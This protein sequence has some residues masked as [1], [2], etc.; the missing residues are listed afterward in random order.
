MDARQVSTKAVA[1]MAVSVGVVVGLVASSA[2]TN[3]YANT[4]S[5]VRPV[6]TATLATVPVAAVRSTSYDIDSVPQVQSVDELAPQAQASANTAG[7]AMGAFVAAG[8]AAGAMLF[9][10]GRKANSAYEAIR[11]DPEAVF[12]NA[13]KAVG[14]VAASAV[15]ASSAAAASLTY[16]EMQSLSYLEMKGSGLSNTCPVIAES[17][18]AKLALKAGNYKINNFCL[19]PSSFQV[20]VPSPDGKT[21]TEFEKTK[22]MTRLTYTLDGIRADLNVGGDGS[23]AIKEIDGIDYAATTVQLAG[24]ER[25]PFLFTVKNLQAKGDAGQFLGQFDVASY[26]GATFLDPKGRG[27]ATGYDTAVALP[28]AGDDEEY[29]KENAKQVGGSVGTIAFKVAKVNAQTGEVAGVFESIQPSDTD[30]GSK[31][32]KDIKTSGVWYAQISPA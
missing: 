25:V 8:A 4:A 1:V 26:R 23:W 2:S 10:M 24:G 5:A 32:A 16:D 18:G 28:A 13:G 29:A 6:S 31:V 3:L 14:A 30:L 9:S 19:E 21:P 11:D 7:W 22:L 20:K 27:G 15:L 17:T 12:A